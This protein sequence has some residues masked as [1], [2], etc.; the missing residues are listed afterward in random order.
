MEYNAIKVFGI[1]LTR[2]G[3]TSLA[4]ALKLV[5]YN[6]IHYP[7]EPVLFGGRYDGAFDLPVVIHYKKLDRAF[8]KSKFI[9]TVREKSGWLDS[10]EKYL[11]SRKV[12][13]PQQ[14]KNRKQVYGQ[15][16][17][18]R[19][20]YS[21]AYDRHH[22]DVLTYF[23]DRPQDLLALNIC[24]GDGWAELRPFLGINDQRYVCFPHEHKRKSR[25]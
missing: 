12:I 21:F 25:S 18:N 13:S 6:V 4:V 16:A 22:N 17:F 19:G 14:N 11:D 2:T 15:S 3:T 10:M 23:A 20:L 1:G 8:P 7:D 9:Y 24:N 5:G